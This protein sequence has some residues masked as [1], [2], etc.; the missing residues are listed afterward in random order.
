MAKDQGCLYRNNNKCT[1]AQKEEV[2]ELDQHGK[3]EKDRGEE[4]AKEKDRRCKISEAEEQSPKRVQR[5]G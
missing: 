2:S 3:L 1:G 4:E 5:E